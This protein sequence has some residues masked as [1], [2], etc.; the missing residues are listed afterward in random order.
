MKS[1]LYL[2]TIV[3]FSPIAYSQDTDGDGLLDTDDL[4]PNN[5]GI[6]SIS[7]DTAAQPD[8]ERLKF[9]VSFIND[10]PTLNFSIKVSDNFSD[11]Y[12]LGLFFWLEGE[13]QT[14]VYP[15]RTDSADPFALSFPLH[16]QAAS[17]TLY[18]ISSTQL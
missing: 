2:L 8:I 14:W 10:I 12:S 6:S 4:C 15:T 5:S 7:S 18:I 13:E 3:I 1:L 17:G 11:T 9:C 16:E